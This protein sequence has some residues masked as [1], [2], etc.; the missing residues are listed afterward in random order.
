M[1]RAAWILILVLTAP[2]LAGQPA[3][4]LTI[5]FG[6]SSVAVAGVTPKATVYIYG[7]AREPKGWSTSVVAREVRLRDDDGD[8]SVVYEIAGTFPWR[9][10]WLAAELEGGAY[11][12][13]APPAYRAQRVGLTS[14]QL[15]KDAAGEVLQLTFDGSLVECIVVRPKTGEVWGVTLVSRGPEDEGTEVGKVTLSVLKLQ[16]RSGTTAPAPKSLKKDDLVFVLDSFRAV[17]G[18]ARVGE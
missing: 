2:R 9:S 8:G 3:K 1:P 16:G 5:T 11:A 4:P 12:A 6:S 10:V 18:V 14:T 15:K 13:A 17:Y 7:L